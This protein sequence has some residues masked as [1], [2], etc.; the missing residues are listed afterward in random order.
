V[1]ELPLVVK[2]ALPVKPP[3]VLVEN[4]IGA[5]SKAVEAPAGADVIRIEEE[6]SI[7]YV[8]EM[9]L[10]AVDVVDTQDATAAAPLSVMLKLLPAPG[11]TMTDCD[12]SAKTTFEP[13]AIS[14]R[15]VCVPAVV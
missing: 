12:P 7:P 8:P 4:V 2:E 15:K 5:L 3:L 14:A 11:R 9:L 1:V 6:S 10:A 13:L